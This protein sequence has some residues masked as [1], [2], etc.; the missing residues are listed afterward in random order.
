MCA[1]GAEAIVACPAFAGKAY[2]WASPGTRR[3]NPGCGLAA[4]HLSADGTPT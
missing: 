1:E 2:G 3:K 4:F